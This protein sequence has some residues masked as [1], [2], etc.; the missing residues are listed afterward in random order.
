MKPLPQGGI[1]F[2]ICIIFIV[3][4]NHEIYTKD[5]HNSD[6]GIP[7]FSFLRAKITSIDTNV[8]CVY[9]SVLNYTLTEAL[10]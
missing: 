2:L 8:M 3:G 4:S 1:L 9:N 10:T 7:I 5:L 6:H